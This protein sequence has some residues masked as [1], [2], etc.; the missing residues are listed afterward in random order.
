MSNM[1]D[2]QIGTA[3]DDLGRALV[4][5]G[6]ATTAVLTAWTLR[7]EPAIRDQV[8]AAIRTGELRPGLRFVLGDDSRA[9]QVTVLLVD[10]ANEY[11]VAAEIT[12]VDGRNLQ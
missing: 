3:A 12:A 2:D 1:S 7:L 4:A 6:E 10:R 5:L 9:P 8:M 11:M